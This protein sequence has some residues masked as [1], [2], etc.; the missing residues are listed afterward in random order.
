MPRPNWPARHNLS[1]ACF[2]VG[3]VALALWFATLA[4]AQEPK[5]SASLAAVR[6]Q[7]A[8]PP[9]DARPM[10]RWWWFGPAV[11]KPELDRELRAMR[12]AGI[13]GAEI[14]PVYPLELDDPAAGFRNH[15]YLSKEFLDRVSFAAQTAHDLNMRLSLTLA[16]GWPYGGAYVPVTNA[17]GKLRVVVDSVPPNASSVPLPSIRNGEKL[18]ASFVAAGT[19]DRYDAEHAN[20]LETIRGDRLMLSSDITGPAVAVFFISSR[21]GQQVKRAAVGAE[22]FV[23]DHFSKE[24]VQSH[25]EHVADPLIAACG[26]NLP[27]SV[28]SDSLEVYGSDWTPDFLSEF[29]RRRGYDLTPLLPEL[30]AGTG[31]KAVDLRYDWGRTLAEL[32]DENYLT[33]LNQWARAHHTRFRSQSYGEPAVTLSSNALVDLPE[34]E[35]SQWHQGF[36]YTRWATSASHIYSRPITSSETWTWLHSPAFSATPLDMKAEADTFFLQGI[37]QLVGHGWPY[38]PPSAGDPGWAFYAAAVF[39]DHNPW[40]IVMPDVTSYLTRVSYLLRQGKPANDIAVFLPEED[41]QGRFSPGHVS[42]SDAMPALLGPDLAPAILD[43][44]YT[45][46]FIDSAA[47]DRVG[48]H[49]PVLILPGVE[50]IPLATYR[51]IQEYA[52]KGGLVIAIKSLPI[53]APGVIESTRDSDAV[54]PISQDLFS[55]KVKNAKRIAG[56]VELAAAIGAVLKPDVQIAPATHEIGFIHRRLVDADIYFV[57]NTGNRAQTVDATFRTEKA[58]AEWW[59]PMNGKVTGAGSARTLRIDLAPYESRVI[60]FTD[61]PA[62]AANATATERFEPIDLTHDWKLTFDKT[63]ETETMPALKSWADGEDAKYYSGTVTYERSVEIPEIVARAHQVIL[64]FGQG[65]PLSPPPLHEGEMRIQAGMRAWYDAPLRDAALV[66]V[67]GKLAGAVWHP[68]YLLDVGPMLHA[69]SNQL[70]IVV[71]NTAINELAGRAAPDYRLLNLRYGERFTRQ[72]M[73]HLEPQPSGILGPLRLVPERD[74]SQKRP[75]Q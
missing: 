10:M 40:W 7:F 17:A 63:G 3:A 55:L 54:K 51:R 50:R 8:N 9:G 68:P 13:G 74:A 52:H 29:R 27:Y 15:P 43:A 1:L 19:P 72:D 28:F 5:D 73:D 66:Y 70:K 23:L 60:V 46:D 69:G 16:S 58:G 75:Q 39:N 18:L 42:V 67:N 57:A 20:Q 21:T 25:I 41:A 14:Q 65:T 48:I 45:F 31:P 22:G 44:G 71:A 35:G 30:V 62:Q 33:P 2:S 56:P 24:A 26:T 32:I 38:S 59:D 4:R 6:A 34:G 12:E 36:S 53:R 37:N 64:D 11:E 61:R 49:Y 47:I